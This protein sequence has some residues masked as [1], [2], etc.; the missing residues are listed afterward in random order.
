MKIARY[1]TLSAL[2]A[3]ACGGTDPA[4]VL[5]I[6]PGASASGVG[7]P[8]GGGDG[9]PTVKPPDPPVSSPPASPPASTPAA[10]SK[11]AFGVTMLNATKPGGETWSLAA[12]P[13]SEARFDPQLAITQNPDGSWKI[14]SAQVR[15]DVF[16][17]SGYTLS[18]SSTQDR[19]TLAS[20]GYM[21]SRNDWRN[22]EITGFVKVN[23]G[24]ADSH[25]TWYARGGKHSDPIPCE[26]SAYK[27]SLTAD[28]QMRFQKESWHVDY[29][30]S[31]YAKV[32]SSYMG[33][34]IGFKT[35]I[36]NVTV[37]GATAVHMEGWLNDSADKV[38]W[39]KV[40]AH[41][42]AGAWGGNSTHC[43]GADD[44][45]PLTWGGPITAFRWDDSSDVDFKWLSVR[46]LE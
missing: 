27:G 19:T 23:A 9:S 30:Q 6:D 44:K 13:R 22:V 42:D 35:I 28:G 38:T 16:T 36:R 15:M 10:A 34:W 40:Y 43:G 7:A 2:I 45:M 31:P 8:P 39:T 33:R 12:D 29:D 46:E 32:T 26:G 18:T 5:P 25:I 3:V 24:G 4:G 41:D 21:Q 11:D 17:S 14:K 20:R 37:N 1:V